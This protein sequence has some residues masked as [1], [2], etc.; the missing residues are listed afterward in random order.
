M[1]LL[2]KEELKRL[3]RE[4][5]REFHRQIYREMRA[6]RRYREERER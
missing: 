6:R 1:P 3:R 2:D 5:E 4:R